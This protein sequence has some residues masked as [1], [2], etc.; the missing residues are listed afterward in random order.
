MHKVRAYHKEDCKRDR[1]YIDDCSQDS[2]PTH[3]VMDAHEICSK[4]VI[5][6]QVA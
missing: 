2:H 5:Q 4:E 6:D 1:Q 3:E